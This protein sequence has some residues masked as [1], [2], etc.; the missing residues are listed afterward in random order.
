MRKF[1]VIFI[2][3]VVLVSGC[4]APEQSIQTNDE[5]DSISVIEAINNA[6]TIQA[7]K[8]VFSFG[9]SWD[10][11]A[12]GVKVGYVKGVPLYLIGDTY[13]LFSVNDNLV[14]SESENF[15]VINNTANVY[16]YNNNQTGYISQ[17]VISLLYKFK[18]YEDD[19]H[20][21]TAEQNFSIRLDADIKDADDNIEWHI[22]RAIMSLGADV[23]ITR[24]DSDDVSGM[25]AMWISLILNEIYEARSSSSN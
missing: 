9:D 23:T 2:S 8:A 24:N 21:G 17:E 22:S 18:I 13:S 1:I 7:K 25:N 6:D 5:L 4:S 19:V 14:G 20:V 15:K 11:Y 16:D 10:I 3:L 12:D